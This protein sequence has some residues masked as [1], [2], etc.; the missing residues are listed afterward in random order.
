MPE[1]EP[2]LPFWEYVKRAFLAKPYIKGLGEV[3]V[4]VLAVFAVGVL[5]VALGPPALLIG[6]GLEIGYLALVSH[7]PRFRKWVH[8]MEM[9]AQSGDHAARK[10]AVMSGLS[11]PLQKRYLALEAKC[12][13]MLESARATTGGSVI[14]AAVY[15][16]VNRLLWIYLKL[17]VSAQ[18]IST[19]VQQTSEKQLLEELE[20]YRRQ[21]AEAAADPAKE[22]I[23]KSLASTLEIA[24]KR[25]EVLNKAKEDGQ[26]IQAEL[27]RIEQQVNLMI[28]EAT[29][30]REAGFLTGRVD[31]VMQTFAQ[32][33][34]WMKA[35]AEILGPVDAELDTPPPTFQVQ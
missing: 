35:N 19:H 4:N 14:D 23:A 21:H 6:A 31:E 16:N 7:D 28:Q 20:M 15:D 33:Q 32:T 27:Q 24:E 30:S 25:L 26:F 1:Q 8:A 18:L 3:P 12:A 34:D 13:K 5:G 17:L 29:L 22:R 9:A 11:Q 10:D 2:T